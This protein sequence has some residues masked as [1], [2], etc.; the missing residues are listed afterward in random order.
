MIASY[1]CMMLHKQGS[2]Q[3][4]H[5]SYKLKL[6]FGNLLALPSYSLYKNYDCAFRVPYTPLH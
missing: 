2:T 1:N 3:I 6:I 5:S 4:N